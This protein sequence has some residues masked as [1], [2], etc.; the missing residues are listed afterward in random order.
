LQI[1]L[2]TLALCRGAGEQP[3]AAWQRALVNSLDFL[4][5]QQNPADG[6]LPNYGA[7]DGSMPAVLTTCDFSDFRPV[8]QALSV[9]TRGERLY[10]RGP[11][12]EE[13]AWLLGPEALDAPLRRQN[14]KSVSFSSTGHQILR[15]KKADNFSILRCGTV[16]ARFSQI[17]MLHLDV[18]WRGHNVLV[19]GGSYL[20]NGP[21]QW[22]KY[23]FSTASHN[24]VQV[25]GHDQMLHY[26]RFKNL[27][28]TK[29]KLLQ[30]RDDEQQTLCAGEHYGFQR[31]IGNCIARRSV[32]FV[33]D[34]LWIVSDLISGSDSHKLR[35][36]WLC[37]TFSYSYAEDEGRLELETPAGQFS[38]GIF[39]ADGQSLKGTVVSGRDDPPRGWISR[40]Y[41]AKEATPSLAVETTSVLPA[42]F[43]SV[44]GAGT[45]QVKIR[46]GLWSVRAGSS[47]VSFRIGDDGLIIPGGDS[48]AN[49]SSS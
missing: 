3:P 35:L 27:Y 47:E 21:E 43:I 41:G 12:D 9:A 7:N 14:Q 1:Y 11:W 2:W 6:R 23:F 17:D 49:L 5:A 19:D 45:P 25:D 33:K 32:L 20:Y 44:L 48:G 13:A 22:H 31:H 18:W 10:D 40:Y 38:I 4:Y 39:D 29:A 15:G 34:D 28:W 36:H 46:D 42:K 16:L 26:R 8:L 30:F 24:T 37:G